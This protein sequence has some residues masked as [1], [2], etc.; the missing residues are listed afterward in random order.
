MKVLRVQDRI[1]SRESGTLKQYLTDIASIKAF[2]IAEE[3]SCARRIA[4]GDAKAIDEL[5]THNLRFVVTVAK[6][7]ETATITLP[8]LINEGNIGLILAAKNYK[9]DMG[10]KFITY[11]VYWIRKLILEYL[12]NHSK[13]VRLPANKISNINKL[14]QRVNSLEQDL[15]REVDIA[16]VIAKYEPDMS[17]ADMID[18]QQISNLRFE[19]FDTPMDDSEGGS[20]Y[21]TI[22]DD[23]EKTTDHII[24]DEDL[25]TQINNVLNILKPRDKKIIVSLFG[26]NGGH[27]LTLKEVSDEIGLTREMIRQIKEKSLIKLRNAFVL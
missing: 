7:Y 15:G 9:L 11:A 16:E 13:L 23:G 18:L 3:E 5:V 20:R 26:L 24:L 27:P 10:F 4:D 8:D 21:D 25:K 14:N 22:A 12:A 2:T 19:S 1:T 6:Q 17:E